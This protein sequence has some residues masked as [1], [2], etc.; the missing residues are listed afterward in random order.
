MALLSEILK[1]NGFVAAALCQIFL[2]SLCTRQIE[3]N[4]L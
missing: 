3:K 2:F 1:Q 4:V